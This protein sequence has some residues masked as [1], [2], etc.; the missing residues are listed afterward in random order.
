[1]L[2]LCFNHD[3]PDLWYSDTTDNT[4]A[5]KPLVST[6]KLMLERTIKARKICSGCPI[7]VDCLAT[8]MQ[9]EN[10]DWGIWGGLTVGERLALA[11]TTI[12]SGHRQGQVAFTRRVLELENVG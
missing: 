6:S 3:D 4:G 7:K 1:M 11:Q 5:G 12:S 2:G 10:L 9:P 8:G